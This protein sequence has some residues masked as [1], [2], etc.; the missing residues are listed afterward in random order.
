ME[1]KR[2]PASVMCLVSTCKQQTIRLSQALHVHALGDRRL[3]VELAHCTHREEPASDE[4][5]TV[6]ACDM[7]TCAILLESLDA[8]SEGSNPILF[9]LVIEAAMQQHPE[10]LRLGFSCSMD[11]F[12]PSYQM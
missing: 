1:D 7:S 9:L 5:G 2:S 10:R 12:L 8:S 6:G 3:N 11:P 4:C